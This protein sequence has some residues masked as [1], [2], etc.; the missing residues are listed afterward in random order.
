MSTSDAVH[1]ELTVRREAATPP[2]RQ[3]HVET[4]RSSTARQVN[5]HETP[6]PQH[7]RRCAFAYERTHKAL[8]FGADKPAKEGDVGCGPRYTTYLVLTRSKN[9]DLDKPELRLKRKQDSCVFRSNESQRSKT[10]G[11]SSQLN[12]QTSV[13]DTSRDV[14]PDSPLPVKIQFLA[15]KDED[16]IK[17]IFS[18]RK[19]RSS[20]PC[21]S[22]LGA[23]LEPTAK[24]RAK[25]QKQTD[26]ELSRSDEV[27]LSSAMVTVLAP[28]WSG[29]LRRS[30]RLEATGSLDTLENLP[31]VENSEATPPRDYSQGCQSAMGTVFNISSTQS[32][33]PFLSSRQNTT[34]WS[35][36]SGPQTLK[37]EAESK[38]TRTVSLDGRSSDMKKAEASTTWNQYGQ[39]RNPQDCHPVR[40][41]S[42]SSKPTTSSLLLSLRKINNQNMNSNIPTPSEVTPMPLSS[43]QDVKHYPTHP[44]Q[45][46]HKT[47]ERERF[48]L[49]PYSLS[50]SSRTPETQPASSLSLTN[51]GKRDVMKTNLFPS[52]DINKVTTDTPKQPQVM[53]REQPSLSGS[54]QALFIRRTS[55]NEQNRRGSGRSLNI[56][57]DNTVSSHKQCQYEA[58]LLSETGVSPRNAS[59]TSSSRWHSNCQ[60]GRLTPV[61]TDTPNVVNKPNTPLIPLCN[62]NCDTPALSPTNNKSLDS[63][64]S[65]N[66]RNSITTESVCNGSI[67]SLKPQKGGSGPSKEKHTD[68]SLDKVRLAKQL[69]ESS[70]KRPEAR[71]S[72]SLLDG[73][74]TM[75]HQRNSIKRDVSN[76]SFQAHV[77]DLSTAMLRPNSPPPPETKTRNNHF[78]LTKN[79]T[80][81]SQTIK[82]FPSLDSTHTFKNQVV[83]SKNVCGFS[84]N[85]NSCPSFQSKPDCSQTNV[86]TSLISSTAQTLKISNTVTTTTSPLGFTRSYSATPSAYQAKAVSCLVPMAKDT[87]KTNCSLASTSTS[88]ATTTTPTQSSS[89][90]AMTSH[91]QTPPATPTSPNLKAGGILT[92]R[93]EKDNKKPGQGQGKRVKHVMWEDSENFEPTKSPDTS[94][95]TIPLSRSRSQRLIRAPSIFSFLRLGSQNTKNTCLTTSPK[96][97]N[98]QVGKGEKYRSLS[99]DFAE[100]TST[101][102]GDSQQNHTNLMGSDQEKKDATLCRLQRSLSLQ[103]DEF[104]RQ[105]TPLTPLSDFSNGYKIRYSPPPYSTL[106][107]N[108]GETK[109]SNLRMPLFQ[110]PYI[111]SN[112]SPPNSLQ[113]DP[114]VTTSN[115]KLTLKNSPKQLSSALQSKMLSHEKSVDSV[116]TDDINNN[117]YNSICRNQQNG[118]MLA[119]SGVNATSQSL[120]TH[121]TNTCATAPKNARPESMQLHTKTVPSLMAKSNEQSHKT[122]SH[123]NQSSSGS[124]STESQSAGDEVGNKR[125]KESVIGKFRLF[126]AENN[127]EQS[128]KRRRFGLKKSLSTP[129]SEP[130]KANKSSNKMDQVISILRH[131]FSTKRPDDE[132]P[133]SKWRQAYDTPSV[134]EL[135]DCSSTHDATIES[136]RNAVRDQQ[137]NGLQE[138][139]AKQGEDWIQKRYSIIPKLSIQNSMTENEFFI[140]PDQ[141]NTKDQNKL[142]TA[143]K[144]LPDQNG[145]KNR[146]TDQFLLCLDHSTGT[147]VRK[148]TSS[149]KSPFS[150]FSSLS[151]HSPFSSPD[152]ANDNV[153]YSP[154]I[155][156]RRESS[157]PCEPGEG[158]SLVSSR[159]SR[160]S[161]GPPSIGPV[162]DDASCYA[163]L[164][165]GIEPGRSVSVSS[166]LSSRPSGP[167]RISTGPRFMSVGDLSESVQTHGQTDEEFKQWLEKHCKHRPIRQ[168]QSYLPSDA[169]KA[170]SRS[171]PRSLTRRLAQWSS[172]VSVCPPADTVS[173]MSPHHWSPKMNVCQF[174]WETVSPPTPPPTPPLSPQPRRMSKPLTPSPPN[175]PSSPGETLDSHSPRGHLPSRGY[176]SSLSTF[177]ESSD[178]SSDTTTDDEYYIERNDDGEEKETEL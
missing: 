178:S 177:E 127:N 103:G 98:L 16:I 96:T 20:L 24:G 164:K 142:T 117:N 31:G 39:K 144:E 23:E 45:P 75:S 15:E 132:L 170:R 36:K 14:S 105:T 99:S 56:F 17:V 26:F 73:Q 162:Q 153:F 35:T 69:H 116:P 63:Q 169:V 154:K 137:E 115:L 38:V 149:S 136:Q 3:A 107:S 82:Q 165:Y 59:E 109:K 126:S 37:Y 97:S 47:L 72:Q 49:L 124:S 175:F 118:C 68:Y 34:G 2:H 155:Q 43:D 70:L 7:S 8:T 25:L 81:Q 93:S 80:N 160:A 152:A 74:P 133:P 168:I 146:D 29:R 88:L 150:P 41:S 110:N 140:Y 121:K 147:K 62:N 131:T 143:A 61:L 76:G 10:V 151:T 123:S 55:E 67:N 84:Q 172:G 65:N 79:N 167:G 12:E 106:I 138:N 174:D 141:S 40:R 101:E 58:G 4:A 52:T 104:L 89:T 71:K 95:L 85:Q 119:E 83:G 21:G 173:S 13:P 114:D 139:K 171:L 6:H 111:I 5:R 48:K 113:S 161:T 78:L 148:S 128:P 57:S 100:R 28:T 87:S 135:S 163:D 30:K 166:V 32:R 27:M 92:N 134:G 112:N 122:L 64:I 125:M 9:L 102:G 44:S 46:S 158:I 86:S 19:S 50:I 54:R 18:S 42:L 91:L 53:N 1:F 159:R 22:Q 77:S 157:S 145:V 66:S 120:Q 90:L 176:I 11:Y 33:A 94:V 156:R 130:E 108:R 129:N 51:Q 60:K